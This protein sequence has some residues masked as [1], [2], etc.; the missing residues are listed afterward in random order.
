MRMSHLVCENCGAVFDENDAAKET[1]RHTE[2]HP[3]FTESWVAC[4]SCLSTDVE[5]AAYCYRCGE[6]VKYSDLVGGYYCKSCIREMR[7][8]H[9][10]ALFVNENIDEF[11]EWLHERRVKN[12]IDEADPK[13]MI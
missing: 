10:E 3:Y 2:I 8:R 1:F 4:P 6:P 13:D 5:D 12:H 7:G 11:A 9:S